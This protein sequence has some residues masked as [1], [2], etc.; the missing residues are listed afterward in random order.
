MNKNEVLAILSIFRATYP[1]AFRDMTKELAVI[2]VNTWHQQLADYP[3][4]VVNR[5]VKEL[6]GKSEYMPSL[7]EVI[8]NIKP[9]EVKQ[10]EY[11]EPLEEVIRK[12]DERL[13]RY[14]ARHQDKMSLTEQQ[15]TLEKVF[16]I[17]RQGEV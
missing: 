16:E 8:K 10:I 15:K 3:A 9:I 7:A 4:E 12:T 11:Q 2:Q 17:L 13:A 6:I 1:I 14:K 5:S